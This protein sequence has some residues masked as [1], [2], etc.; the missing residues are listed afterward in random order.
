MFLLTEEEEVPSE[1]TKEVMEL[2]QTMAKNAL[3]AT[4]VGKKAADRAVQY[5]HAVC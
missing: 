3:A 1:A 5:V 4:A 2:A